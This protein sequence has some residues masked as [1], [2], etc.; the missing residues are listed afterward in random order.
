[1]MPEPSATAQARERRH[2]DAS[3]AHANAI[4]EL[5]LAVLG[6]GNLPLRG[7]GLDLLV[8]MAGAQDLP[9]AGHR[10]DHLY[11]DGFLLVVAQG[12][13]PLDFVEVRG[14]PLPIL[15]RALSHHVERL[16]HLDPDLL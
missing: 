13:L 1:M 9:V 6:H 10:L 3:E 4:A 15:L 5:A 11:G 7:E 14:D 16:A 2:V 8:G 12:D